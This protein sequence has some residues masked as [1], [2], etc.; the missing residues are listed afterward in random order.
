L[1]F[2]LTVLALT[3]QFEDAPMVPDDEEWSNELLLDNVN[4][5]GKLCDSAHMNK[6]YK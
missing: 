3:A 5:L 4:G 2:F 6:N 1:D